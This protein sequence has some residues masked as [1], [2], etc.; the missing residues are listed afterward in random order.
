MR[1]PLKVYCCMDDDLRELVD[2]WLIKASN[3][4]RA[5]RIVELVKGCIAE[6]DEA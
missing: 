6:T 2:G 1:S 5:E 4:A 3:D